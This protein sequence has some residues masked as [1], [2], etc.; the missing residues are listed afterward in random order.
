MIKISKSR[1]AKSSLAVAVATSMGLASQ[2]AE[3]ANWLK[4]YNTSP[5]GIAKPVKLWGFIQP[6]YAA[7]NGKSVSGLEGPAAVTKFNGVVPNFNKIGPDVSSTNTFNMFRARI[8]IRGTL[9]P[10]SNKVDYFLLTEF[11]NNGMTYFAGKHPV[12]SDAFVTWNANPKLVRFSLGLQK[13]PGGWESR[14]GIPV[15]PFVNYSTAALQ[16]TLERFISPSA[17]VSSNGSGGYVFSPANGN[18][19]GFGSYRDQGLKIFN[20]FNEGHWEYAYAFMIGN[21]GPI[22]KTN[23][24]N[25]MDTYGMLRASYVF[26]GKGPYRNDAGV[27]VWYHN[28]QR[29]IDT[30]GTYK[31]NRWGIGGEYGRHQRQ[32]GG[33]VLHAGYLHA[34]GWILTPAPFKGSGP[35]PLVDWTIYPGSDNTAWGAY[36]QGGYYVTHNVELQLRYDQYDRLTNNDALQRNFKE[37]TVGAQY[38]LTKTTRITLNYAIRKLDVPHPGAITNPVQ[39]NNAQAIANTMGNRL[40]LE[41]T[42]VF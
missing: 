28:G 12:I 15:L 30:I 10:L 6:D 16:N 38:F 23:N 26:S 32:P 42:S 5:P 4:L 21:G 11:G 25:G 22:N 17:A 36:A 39:R 29:K 41:L 1:L 24:N 27:W 2:S 14:V 9:T 34:S 37:W 7:T 3:A 31:L 8:G 13:V 19:T 40:D 35:A 33:Y 20:W 18:V